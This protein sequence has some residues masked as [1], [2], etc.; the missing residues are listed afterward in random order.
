MANKAINRSDFEKTL[1]LYLKQAREKLD[2][3]LSGTRD[4]IKLIAA[5]K[6]RSFI[7][8]TD[9]GLSKDEREFLKSLIIS[10]MRQSFCY[11]YG[12]G[13]FE[14]NTNERVYL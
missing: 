7:E 12:I 6:T 8:I 1:R 11:G 5:D 2:G 14:G 4:A 3:D 10:S 13:K 9:R